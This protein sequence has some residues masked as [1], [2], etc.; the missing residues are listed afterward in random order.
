VEK[1]GAWFDNIVLKEDPDEHGIVA[2]PV[3]I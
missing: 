1:D 3:V 2:L